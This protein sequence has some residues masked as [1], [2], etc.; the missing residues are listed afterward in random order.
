VWG[1]RSASVTVEIAKG[2]AF[3][4]VTAG[5]LWWLL[6]WNRRE[7]VRMDH[8]FKQVLDNLADAVLVLRLPERQIEYVNPAVERIFGY[9]ADDLI[10]QSTE[11]LHLDRA[12]YEAFHNAGIPDLERNNV[13]VGDFEMRRKDGTVFRSSHMVTWFSADHGQELA[14]SLVRDESE[15]LAHEQARYHAERLDALGQLAAGIVHDFNNQL[16]VIFACLDAIRDGLAEGDPLT[17]YADQGLATGEKA[18]VL[19][20]RLLSFASKQDLQPQ[21]L[22]VNLLVETLVEDVLRR[23]LGRSINVEMHL[24]PGLPSAFMDSTELERALLNV[25]VNA[26]DA[27]PSGGDLTIQTELREGRSPGKDESRYVAVSVADSGTGMSKEAMERL[28]EPFFSTKPRDQGTG[29]GLS[30]SYGFLRQS[31]GDLLVESEPG[32]GAT[33]TL[34]LPLA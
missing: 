25:A 30:G 10:G 32:R 31:G 17:E 5:L 27:M 6:E 23:T 21:P 8:R 33:F 7:S 2:L 12:H 1:A 11:L 14:V 16:I 24:Q 34:L 3:V 9:R 4:L 13:Y 20:R 18:A 28:F 29:L 26:R 19:S 22:D 15:R